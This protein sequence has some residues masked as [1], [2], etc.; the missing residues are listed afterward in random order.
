MR[1]KLCWRRASEG[2]DSERLESYS[3]AQLM[4]RIQGDDWIGSIRGKMEREAAHG[5]THLLLVQREAQDITLAALVLLTAVPEI[6]VQQ[7]DISARLIK[8]GKLGRR[9]KNHAMNGASPTLWLQDNRGG[10]EVAAALWN[11]PGVI[12]LTRSSAIQ[13][14]PLI[15]EEI[16]L[17]E[18]FYEGA[19]KRV[20]VNA[21]ERDRKARWLCIEHYGAACFVCGFTFKDVYGEEADGLIHVHHL[22]PLATVGSEYA[23]DPITDLRPLCPNCHAVAHLNGGCKPIEELQLMVNSGASRGEQPA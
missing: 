20:T 3:A 6:W 13:H 21:Y 4:A 14:V 17:P 9:K 23:V 12:D 19:C 1:V 2:R 16:G 11:H 22:T 10:E 15:P 5:V 7:R 18:E 8:D